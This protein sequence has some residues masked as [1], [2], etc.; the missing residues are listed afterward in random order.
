MAHQFRGETLLELGRFAEAAEAL[1]HYLAKGTPF[2]ADVAGPRAC[3][4]PSWAT[5]RERSRTIRGPWRSSGWRAARRPHTLASRGWGYLIQEAPKLAP[6][7]LRRRAL[8]RQGGGPGGLVR[9]PGLCPRAAGSMAIGGEP[10]PRPPCEK[11]PTRGRSYNAAR[12]LR[13]PPTRCSATRLKNREAS[14]GL[15]RKYR[16]SGSR[17]ARAR[18]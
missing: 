6:A 7:R 9:R 1:D 5:M 8:K 10:T 12:I 14:Q 11:E 17:T 15:A 16:A 13:R 2:G 4:Q 18:L 3:R